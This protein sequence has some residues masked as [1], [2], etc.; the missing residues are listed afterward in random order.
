MRRADGA[1]LN[2]RGRASAG[3]RV[4]ASLIIRLALAEC[5]CDCGILALDEPTTNL[6]RRNIKQFAQML[7]ELAQKL[8]KK[9]INI[10][11]EHK[12]NYSASKRLKTQFVIITHDV[13]FVD[14]LCRFASVVT[15]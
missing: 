4:L 10:K 15:G 11:M 12:K 3:Q 6:D 2:M 14:E 8:V 13:E 7:G 1:T 5:F 9:K